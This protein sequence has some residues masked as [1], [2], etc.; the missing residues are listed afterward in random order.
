[1]CRVSDG[2]PVDGGLLLKC[3]FTFTR[4]VDKKLIFVLRYWLKITR[5]YSL[6]III[7]F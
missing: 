4:S 2:G 1:M 3:W 5:F 7:V 6:N